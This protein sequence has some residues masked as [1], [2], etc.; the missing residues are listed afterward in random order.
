MFWKKNEPVEVSLET[1]DDNRSAYRIAP[2]SERPVA[3]SIDGQEYEVCNI[4]G[5]GIAFRSRDFAV[6]SN[7]P[8]SLRLPGEEPALSMVIEVVTKQ[9][10]LCRCRFREIPEDAENLL[11]SYILDLQKTKIRQ[12]HG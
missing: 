8:A 2:D 1:D 10:E 12:R 5:S 7:A 4:S 6:G 9:G 11:H 3:L